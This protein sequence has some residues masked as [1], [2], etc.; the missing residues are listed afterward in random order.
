MTS[1]EINELFA[2][3]LMGDY[4]DELPW[5]A[6][7]ALRRIGTREVFDRAAAWCKS[8]NPMERARGVSVLAQL[9]KTAEHPTSN[10]PEESYLAV[11]QMLQQENEI[12][13]L[14]SAIHALGHLDNPAAVP[15]ISSYQQHPEADV[16]FAVACALGSFANDPKAIQVLLTLTKDADT[17][18][19]DWAVF[20]LGNLGD[21]DSA[22]I[23]DAL[24]SRLNDSDEAVREEAL[25]GLAKCKDTRVLP[26]LL[27]A[28]N[29]SEVDGPGI[30]KLT[31]EA[32][33]AMLGLEDERGDWGGTEYIAALRER[34][35]C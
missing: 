24:F 11:S 22:E 14:G 13:P 6:V 20:G 27:A 9:G 33:N 28:L 8:T 30:T 2:Q 16:R 15:L 29:Q 18:V 5:N 3:T 7:S 23:R 21:A 19:R 31:I 10:F 35:S 34:F 17:D 32:A 1:P 25:V 12:Q 4:D 26:A